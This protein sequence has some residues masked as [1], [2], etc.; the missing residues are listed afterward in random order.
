MRLAIL[1]AT[2]AAAVLVSSCAGGDHPAPS[3]T[4]ALPV[5][6]APATPPAKTVTYSLGSTTIERGVTLALK[7]IVAP[8]NAPAELVIDIANWSKKSGPDLEFEPSRIVVRQAGRRIS[9]KAGPSAGLTYGGSA[10]GF[11]VQLTGFRPNLPYTITANVVADTALK[12][13]PPGWHRPLRFYWRFEP[14]SVTA[15]STA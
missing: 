8:P 2:L 3:S 7:R 12:K 6:S 10:T 11:T 15:S 1:P 13:V 4:A 14:S 5:V 9:L